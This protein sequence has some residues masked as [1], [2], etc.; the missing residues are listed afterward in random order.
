MSRPRHPLS[1]A[2]E[3]SEL[4]VSVQAL[5][6]AEITRHDALGQA[7]RLQAAALSP[8]APRALD[9]LLLASRSSALSA[10]LIGQGV[11]YDATY[12]IVSKHTGLSA[13]YIRLLYL[14]ERNHVR[15][16]RR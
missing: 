15:R 16:T 3:A 9:R 1:L 7:L 6:T 5:W 2:S 12:R 11:P 14:R 10:L 8:T 4:P 13:S